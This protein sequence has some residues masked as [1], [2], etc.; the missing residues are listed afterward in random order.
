M[1]D[2]V[3][4]QLE[5]RSIDEPIMNA[6]RSLGAGALIIL[7]TVVAYLPAL[8]DGFIWDDDFY[9]TENQ[10]LRSLEGLGRIWSRPGTTFQYYPL[11]F[12]SFWA[13]Y[14]L[15]KL[16]PFG[17]H[18]V[19]VLLHALNAVLLWRVLRRLEVPGS[20]WA[21]AL[22]A[23]HPV[24]VE[25]VAWITERKNVL[26]CAFYLLAVLAYF[27]FRP[28]AGEEGTRVRDWRLYPLVLVL[29]LCALLSKTVACSLPA[30]LVLLVWWKTGQ[31][32]RR[33]ALELTPLFVLGAALGF[34]TA[35]I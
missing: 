4:I 29:F 28:L 34:G 24:T 17:Y 11:T 7:L 26:S 14:H 5:N 16:Q 1:L 30:V 35:W 22:F 15:W 6:W 31:F 23:V 19:N 32:A 8:R 33:D 2:D 25:S 12:T 3:M 18:L 27:R 21:A 10:A 9:V 13:E 20:W